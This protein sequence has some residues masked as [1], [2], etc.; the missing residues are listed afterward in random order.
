MNTFPVTATLVFNGSSFQ[1]GSYQIAVPGISGYTTHLIR[2]PSMW[3][4]I[5]LPGH[6]RF[7]LLRADRSRRI[8][9]SPRRSLT[10]G[11]SMPVATQHSLPGTQCTLSPPNP[12]TIGNGTAAAVTA[13]V[14][15]PNTG[16]AGAYNINIHTQDASGA[17]VHNWTVALTVGQDFTIG[18][19]TPSSQTVTAGRSAS[20]NF[21]VLPVGASFSSAGICSVPAVPGSRCAASGPTQSLRATTGQQW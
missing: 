11:R 12:I 8:S 10:L 5:R 20:Y 6:K 19:L 21:S 9:R 17:P 7:P 13:T 1:A 4:I 18:A 15:V 14:N 16:P 2:C 3:A